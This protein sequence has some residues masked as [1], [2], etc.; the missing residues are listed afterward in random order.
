MCVCVCVCVSVLV[1]EWE[2][3]RQSSRKATHLSMA[4]AKWSRVSF[5]APWGP[6]PSLQLFSRMAP[7]PLPGHA[8]DESVTE[9]APH[10]A[11]ANASALRSIPGQR[12][13]TFVHATTH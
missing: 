11:V 9:H 6:R 4:R 5:A 13:T 2:M 12:S 3:E 7:S 1:R 10:S 8:H